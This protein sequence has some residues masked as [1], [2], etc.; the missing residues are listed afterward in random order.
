MAYRVVFDPRADEIRRTLPL[1]A[2]VALKAKL[3]LI[4]KDPTAYGRQYG[5]SPYMRA[6]PFGGNDQG[7]I[8]YI[9]DMRQT[10][11]VTDIVWVE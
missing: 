4:F 7:L 8:I 2:K 9:D 11:T 1:R 3:A 10:I 5:S 6:C